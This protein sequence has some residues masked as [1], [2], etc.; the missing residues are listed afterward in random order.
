MQKLKTFR[1]RIRKIPIKIK[2]PLFI[3][4]LI[5][6]IVGAITWATS[7]D[8]SKLMTEQGKDEINVNA[9]R[10]SEGMWT[11]SKMQQQAAYLI[12][13]TSEFR[14][15]LELRTAGTLP[16]DAF[17]SGENPYLQ[18]ANNKLKDMLERT[19]GNQTLLVYD[20]QGIIVASSNPKIVGESRADRD[21]V[22]AALKGESVIS[23]AVISQST[24]T[25]IIAYAHPLTN[26]AGEII[27]AYA[28]TVDANF[29]ISQIGDIS[30]NDK[31]KIQIISRGG[32]I[33]YDSSNPEQ[34]GGTLEGMDEQLQL[35]AD[36]AIVSGSMD[37]DG[38]YIRYDK[39]PGSDWMII[40]TDSYHDIQKPVRKLLNDMYIIATFFEIVAIVLGLLI[41]RMITVP[42]TQF[43]GLFKKLADGDLRIKASDK[44]SGEFDDL[45]QSFNQ[46]VQSN[47]EIITNMNSSIL[48]LNESTNTLEAS[49]KAAEV[50]INETTRTT[51]EIANAMNMQ[52]SDT[53]L[54]VNHFIDF[55]ERFKSMNDTANTANQSA[56]DIVNVF[57]DS[58]QVLV[59]LSDINDK[60]EEEV[61]KISD[62]TLR[63][64]ESSSSIG[65]ITKTING[66]AVQTNLLALNASIE[67]ARAG[68]HGRGFAVV[69]SEIRKLA[70]QSAKQ[71]GEIQQIIEQNL[72]YVAENNQSVEEIKQISAA[73]DEHVSRT[74][75]AFK[76]IY[77][78]VT[79][80]TDRIKELLEELTQ[81]G[82]SK[83]VIMASVQN[84]S[85]AGEEVSASSEEVTATMHEQAS[86][87]KQ[88]SS[89]SETIDLLTRELSE[90]ASKFILK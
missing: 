70:E 16:G 75:Q 80:I 26:A 56:D 43:K 22:K 40:V 72:V 38:D 85:A 87:V 90:A 83:D 23:D 4:L 50:S 14:N 64:Q 47:N 60:N 78:S 73:Q 19:A 46:M 54:I 71:V 11:A 82:Q 7:T 89:M 48:V 65:Q 62:I 21:Y 32:T 25:Q 9:D 18:T 17:F 69:A 34:S 20:K 76:D 88:L 84:L 30:I 12:S 51:A 41:S 39:I 77:G 79:E 52:A 44:Y 36:N 6:A 53:E 35:Q 24:N 8:G 57:H 68:E 29:F 58:N 5:I 49:S 59:L 45:A 13:T 42:I 81:L 15:L 27:G 67:A 63:L 2:L 1:Q 33:L 3:A 37:R 66:I 31:G 55:G 10:I 61:R 28:S 86:M 74:K